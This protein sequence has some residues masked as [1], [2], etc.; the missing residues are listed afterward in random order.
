MALEGGA[1]PFMV[2][3]LKNFVLPQ[4]TPIRFPVAYAELG[5]GIALVSGGS[6]AR[7]KRGRAPS[8]AH[9]ACP[10]Q[11]IRCG[12]PVLAVLRR[13]VESTRCW[14]CVW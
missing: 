10:H 6:G 9:P 4:A 1:Y 13:I 12:S 2:P 8:H 14:Q 5:I 11:I 7:S 3:V